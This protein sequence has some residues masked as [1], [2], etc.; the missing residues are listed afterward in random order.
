MTE[1]IVIIGG[2]Q[3][4]VQ[5][6]VSLCQK[7]LPMDATEDAMLELT[8]GCDESSWLCCQLKASPELD[9]IVVRTPGGQH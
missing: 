4:R 2:G 6:A 9:G 3:A 1:T 8:D 5:A 7:R